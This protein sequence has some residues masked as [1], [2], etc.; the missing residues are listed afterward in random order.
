MPYNI[1]IVDDSSSMRK[2]LKK[3]ITMCNI[4]HIEFIEAENGANALD[5]MNKN[6]IDLVFTDI[7]MPVMDGFELIKHLKNDNLLG[8][9]PIIVITSELRTENT[10]DFKINNI[11][12]II[13][14][15]FRPESIRELLI[16]LLGLEECDE[17]D[18]GEVE[19]IDF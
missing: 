4:G 6:W 13:Y 16:N 8:N 9:T 19:G 17:S 11:K 2:V 1:L 15:P 14:K 3:A 12:H 10:E 5:L 7:N 18:N